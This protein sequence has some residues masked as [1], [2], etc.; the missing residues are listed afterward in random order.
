MESS[1]PIKS[2]EGLTFSVASLIIPSR[3]GL[4]LLSCSL[5]FIIILVFMAF[6]RSKTGTLEVTE[7]SPVGVKAVKP[8]M[9]RFFGFSSMLGSEAPI[10]D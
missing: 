5:S 2:L 4:F 9:K 6:Y 10:V 8:F 1:V 3:F 7:A